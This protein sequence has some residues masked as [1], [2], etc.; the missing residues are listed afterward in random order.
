MF[1]LTEDSQLTSVVVSA[2]RGS[3]KSTLFT[4]SFPLWAILGE[5]KAKYI[6]ILS[7]TQQK[8]Q[9]FLQHI[10]YQLETNQQ[11]KNDLGPFQ[12]ERSGWNMISL[13]LP[14]YKAKISIASVEQS[15]R[16]LRHNQHR[17]DLIICDDLEDLDSVKTQESRD[18]TYAWLISDVLPTGSSHTR[19]VVVGSLLHQDSIIKKLQKS[20][21]D[22]KM[23][24][25]YRAYPILDSDGS[26]TWP[27]KYPNKQAIEAEKKRGITDIVWRR[28]YMLEI[29]P[30]ENQIVREEWIQKYTTLPAF[31]RETDHRYAAVAIDLAISESSTADYTAMVMAEVYGS[32]DTLR[33]HILPNPVNER[34]TFPATYERIKLIVTALGG[35]P[36]IIIEDVGYQK[37]VIQRLTADGYQAEGFTPH[38]N[39]KPA[40]LSATTHLIQSGHVLFPGHG[41]E[42]LIQQLLG[43]GIEKHDDLVD[44][45]AMLILKIMEVDNKPRLVIPKDP[46]PPPPPTKEQLEKEA[47]EE[48]RRIQEYERSQYEELM[49]PRLR[50]YG[51]WGY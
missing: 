36:K 51:V 8:A 47:D 17:P 15:V 49:R 42:K 5:Q 22:E 11:L 3:G 35:Y 9:L 27:G 16:G 18:K 21:E 32:R 26:P 19:L 24:G 10:K 20:I 1:H 13:Y 43:F 45:F 40:R 50:R 4:M 29:V 31:S 46:P 30:D 41:A 39:D 7:K 34:L 25:V 33:I 6:L 14:N 44:A 38:G 48:V 23:N 28:E 37:S 2:F 12:E